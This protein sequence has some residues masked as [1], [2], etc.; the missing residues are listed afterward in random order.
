MRTTASLLRARAAA[1]EAA[2]TQALTREA[3]RTSCWARPRVEVDDVLT[4]L[5]AD[6]P[7]AERADLSLPLS[8]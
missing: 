7:Q 6:F 3:T 4:G 8:V 2:G 5:V 1:G